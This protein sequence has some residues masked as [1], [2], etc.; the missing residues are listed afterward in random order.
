[1]NESGKVKLIHTGAQRSSTF[2][3][4]THRRWSVQ[5]QYMLYRLLSGHPLQVKIVGSILTWG[6][7]GC[8]GGLW[9]C[10]ISE[11]SLWFEPAGAR[12]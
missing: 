3:S 2:F 9:A 7:G 11:L 12:A 10:G 8:R 6:F 4:P 1:M 5:Y